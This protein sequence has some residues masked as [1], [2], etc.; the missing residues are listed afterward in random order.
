MQRRSKLLTQAYIDRYNERILPHLS[1]IRKLRLSGYSLESI[2]SYLG[3]TLSQLDR[4][5]KSF[6]DLK[7]ALS[8]TT[9][10]SVIEV[11]NALYNS[12]FPRIKVLKT[13][14]KDKHG[15]VLQVVEKE[16]YIPA[17]QRAQEFFLKSKAPNQWSGDIVDTTQEDALNKI[18]DSLSLIITPKAGS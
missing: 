15:N 6:P 4:Y 13:T 9:E 2:C 16:T 14:T 7:T 12:C 11:T 1:A 17:S 10:Q 3:L 8:L 18:C 5:S